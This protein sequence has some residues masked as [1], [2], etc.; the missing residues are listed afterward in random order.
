M[1]LILEKFLQLFRQ[2]FVYGIATVFPRVISVILVRI[3]TDKSVLSEVS[4]FGTLSLIF[5][6]VILFN[7][8]LS[9][10]LETSF[11]RFYNSEK[12][13]KDVVSTS[14]VSLIFSTII[15]VSIFSIFKSNISQFTGIGTG[16]LSIVIWVIAFLALSVM[17]FRYLSV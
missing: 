5:S 14:A 3:H 15:F 2:T 12:N 7:V 4:E 16:Y 11:F 10:G 17:R 13:K 1:K 9:Y 6:Y 8:I